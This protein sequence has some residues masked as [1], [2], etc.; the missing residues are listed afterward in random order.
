[1]PT[2]RY[3]SIG[4]DGAVTA[5]TLFA[6]DRAGAVRSI[7]QRG[8]TALTMSMVDGDTDGAAAIKRR[9][10]ISR[11]ELADFIRELATA[12]EAGLPLMSA[13]RTVHKQAGTPKLRAILDYIIDRVEAGIPLFQAAKEYGPPFDDMTVG[14]MRAA[15]A[16]GRTSEV[17][18]QLADLLERSVELRREVVGAVI[19][20]AMVAGLISVSVV[21]MI[22]FVLPR[23]MQPIL[24]SG[25][26]MPLPTEILL[27]M[28]NFIASWWYLIGATFVMVWYGSKAWHANPDNRLRFDTAVLRLPV[29]GRLLRDIAVARFTRTLGT[30]VSAGIPILSALRIVR[31]TLGNHALMNAIDHVTEK[32]TTGQSLADPLER[33]GLFPPLL[34]QIVNIGERSGRLEQM[35]MHAAGS[36]DRQVNNSLKLFTRILPTVLLVVMAV[37]AVFVLAAILLPILE[38]QQS[39]G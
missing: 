25:R 20:P 19:Y 36:F 28:S 9:P 8:E 31:D 24:A 26:P 1:M 33:S 7:A 18:H 2:F 34:V 27:A 16:S 29:V 23:I 11:S 13:L 32:V 30:L 35:L 17:L 12:I 3:Q 22:V 14:M 4:A 6:A 15:D 38:L 37:V 5:G 39:V 10:T 21:I